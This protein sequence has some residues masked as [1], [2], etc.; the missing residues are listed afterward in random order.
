MAR[1]AAIAGRPN[2][3]SGLRAC[4]EGVMHRDVRHTKNGR[5]FYASASRNTAP[6]YLEV[7][8]SGLGGGWAVFVAVLPLRPLE[9]DYHQ[10]RQSERQ[11]Q[12]ET[13]EHNQ[14]GE[15]VRRR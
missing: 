2:A 7:R 15:Y 8:D 14:C 13:T 10:Q 12:V 3:G 4:P 9:A 5:A 11:Q 6:S 1:G